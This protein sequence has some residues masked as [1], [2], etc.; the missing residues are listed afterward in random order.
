[1]TQVQELARFVAKASWE[2]IADTTREQIKI[3]LLD[4]L[5]CAIGA[6]EGEPVRKVRAVVDQL[7]SRGRCTLI[8]GGTAAPDRAALYNSALIRYLDFND[9]Y[10]AK[11]ETGHPSDNIAAIL[12]AGECVNA[13]GRDLVT[14]IAVAYQVQCRLCEMAPVRDHG[15]DHATQLAYSSAAGA[16][17]IL[18]LEADQTASAIALSGTALNSLRVTRTG[19]LSH[20]KGLADPFTAAAA[21]QLV[22]LARQGIT[23]PM[24]VFEGNKGFM[25][26]IAGRFKIDWA[27]EGMDR[28]QKTLL[29]KYNAETHSQTAI[30]SVLQ[31]RAEH[32]IDP[33]EVMRVEVRIF[34]VAHKIIGGGEEGD[35]ARVGTKEEADHSLPYV[36]AVALLDGQV[37]TQQYRPERIQRPDVQDLLR[38]VFIYPDE[39][40]SARF[41]DEMMAAVCILL[42][43]GQR[44]EREIGSLEPPSW[45]WAQRKF[46][47]LTNSYTSAEQCAAIVGVVA[48]LERERVAD[49]MTLLAA[50]KGPGHEMPRRAA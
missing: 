28:V 33:A 26:A 48:N 1:M 10:L 22:L 45:E 11:G 9:N 19:A 49:L 7:D 15:F 4:A 25:D 42:R 38:K 30:E 39:A 12:A 14:A 21:L 37:M 41:P 16:A 44:L 18:G 36:L 47:M 24:E 20:W 6:Q 43:N 50:V 8:G 29:K 17:K 27:H 34:D 31:L 2:A 13:S 35:K 23:A 3:R 5:A 40:Y 32:K 46:G